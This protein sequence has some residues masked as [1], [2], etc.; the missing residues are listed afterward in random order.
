[1]RSGLEKLLVSFGDG[2]IIAKPKDLNILLEERRGRVTP[3][4][5]AS[6]HTYK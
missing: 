1:M 5:Q 3:G 4:I 2:K 6:G